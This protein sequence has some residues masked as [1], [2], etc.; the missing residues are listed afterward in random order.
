MQYLLTIVILCTSLIGFG[1]QTTTI[2]LVIKKFDHDQGTIRAG[3]YNSEDQW[4]EKVFLDA[5]T[6][7]YNTEEVILYFSDIPMGEYAISIY[8]DEND[9]GDLDT[10]VMGIPSED[11]GFSNN[12]VGSFGPAKYADAAFQ[13]SEKETVHTINLN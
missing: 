8:H 1:Q 4:L 3:L 11:Y 6:T 7:I 2:K 10:Y 13:V 5:D 12:A 9:N